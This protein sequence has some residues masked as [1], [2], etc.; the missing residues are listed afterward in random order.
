MIDVTRYSERLKDGAWLPG[1]IVTDHR[2]WTQPEEPYGKVAKWALRRPVYAALVRARGKT[3]RKLFRTPRAAYQ[4]VSAS[5]R[6]SIT[7][8]PNPRKW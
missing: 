4:W 2:G 1:M 8:G 7:N 6:A 3:S 5:I